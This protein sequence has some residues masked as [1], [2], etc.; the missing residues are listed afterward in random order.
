[1]AEQEKTFSLE[2][3]VWDLQMNLLHLRRPLAEMVKAACHE[4][5]DG[6]PFSEAK[7]KASSGLIMEKTGLAPAKL[8]LGGLQ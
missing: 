1:M 6:K 4:L 5:G 2:H 7:T 8:V 3:N